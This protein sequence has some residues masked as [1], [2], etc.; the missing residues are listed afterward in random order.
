[1]HAL[2]HCSHV[3]SFWLAAREVLDLKLSPLHPDTW[4]W[5]LV[6]DTFFSKTDRCKIITIMHAIWNSR[7]RWTHGEEGYN[8]IQV[9]KRARDD[10]ALL[11]LPMEK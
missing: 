8:P 1:M 4:S 2:V 7:N 6:L 3:R 5:D 11:D 10:L 9:V